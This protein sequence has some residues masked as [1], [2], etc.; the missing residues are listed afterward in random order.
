[1]KG[2]A[3]GNKDGNELIYDEIEFVLSVFYTQVS[4]RISLRP[5]TETSLKAGLLIF[6]VIG[7][8]MRTLSLQVP[9]P[10]GNQ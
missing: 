7:A 10:K 6:T 2:R 5:N 4:Q 9:D 8:L 3:E 1:M